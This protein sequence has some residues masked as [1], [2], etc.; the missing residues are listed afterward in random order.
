MKKLRSASLVTFCLVGLH[1][2]A[3]EN[4]VQRTL[5]MSPSGAVHVKAYK[6]SIDVSAGDG[7]SV[8]VVAR[9]EPDG[10]DRHQAEKVAAVKIRIE[11]AGDGVDIEADYSD[12]ESRRF[13]HLF[14]GDEGA[15]PFVRFTIRMPRTASLEVEDYKS[16]SKIDGVHGGVRLETYKGHGTVTGVEGRLR[17]Q[18]YKGDLRVEAA[19]LDRDASLEYVDIRTCAPPEPTL[20]R[21]RS[22]RRPPL[23]R[24]VTSTYKGELALRL[25]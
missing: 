21:R 14:S 7:A 18:T 16:A 17:I 24:A 25:R 15:L 2:F 23:V 4:R 22:D 19:R 6:G 3:A 1:A 9:V 13:W 10:D 11:K 12:V 5:E 8:E 20:A